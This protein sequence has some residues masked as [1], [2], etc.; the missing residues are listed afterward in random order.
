MHH[1][2]KFNQNR[3]KGCTDIMIRRFS[4]WRPSAILDFQN[5]K[6]G[7][8]AA[9]VQHASSRQIAL[10]SVERSQTYGDLTLFQNGSRPPSWICW[11]STG[12]THDDHLVVFIVVPNLVKINAVVSI[13]WNFQY[14]ANL[15]WKRLF[16]PP[17]LF[18]LG[19]SPKMGSNI[20][21]TPKRH[22]SGS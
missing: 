1:R 4:Q 20:N 22:I 5:S 9:R 6:F 19:I 18:F 17:K 3:S 8:F 16:T 2:A 12:T 13:T 7:R 11:A 10:K 14:F 21:K 15:A